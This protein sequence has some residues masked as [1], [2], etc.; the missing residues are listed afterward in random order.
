M[1]Y[2]GMSVNPPGERVLPAMA[3][4]TDYDA[5]FVDA[6]RTYYPRVFAYIYARTSDVE[7][8]KD[9]TAET[10]VKVYAK[11]GGLRDPGAFAGWL[12]SIARNVTTAHYRTAARRSNGVERLKEALRTAGTPDDPGDLSVR[13]EQIETLMRHLPSLTEREQHLIALRFDAGL[14]TAEIAEATGLTKVS[15]RVTIFRALTKLRNR[16][17]A[18]DNRGAANEAPLELA[19]VTSP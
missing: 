18:E 15:V 3:P 19:T 4:L 17:N 5:A 6:Y 10:F 13:R 14:T 12:F 16:I 7:L 8:S 1:D 9:L 2:S 11:A